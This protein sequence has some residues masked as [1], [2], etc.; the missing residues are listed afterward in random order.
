MRIGASSIRVLLVGFHSIV[1]ARDRDRI[2]RSSE[3]LRRFRSRS[4]LPPMPLWTGAT[5][6]TTTPRA[7]KRQRFLICAAAAHGS[8]FALGDPLGAQLGPV[9]LT[10]RSRTE[11]CY[12]IRLSVLPVRHLFAAGLHVHER[13]QLG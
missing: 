4:R 11:L 2:G 13:H 12:W 5:I 1:A 10:Q 3:R 9:G 6:Q 7:P 8:I